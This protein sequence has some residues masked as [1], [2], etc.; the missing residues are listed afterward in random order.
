MYLRRVEVLPYPGKDTMQQMMGQKG[1]ILSTTK[2]TIKIELDFLN[3]NKKITIS[4]QNSLVKKQIQLVTIFNISH[5][6]FFFG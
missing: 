6:C 3:I 1:E 2:M 5:F 4:K